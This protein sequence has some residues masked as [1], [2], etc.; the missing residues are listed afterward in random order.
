MLNFMQSIETS[1]EDKIKVTLRIF[2]LTESLL[3]A[4]KVFN[5]QIVRNFF[6]LFVLFSATSRNDLKVTTCILVL[7]K[8]LLTVC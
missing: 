4:R 1:V 5:E 7:L 3:L 6:Y 2:E 8:S